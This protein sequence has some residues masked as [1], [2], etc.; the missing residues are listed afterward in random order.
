MAVRALVTLDKLDFHQCIVPSAYLRRWLTTIWFL[1]HFA[2][3][4]RL[5][6][7]NAGC[8]RF[9]NIGGSCKC[10][11]DFGGSRSQ[12]YFFTL[13]KIFKLVHSVA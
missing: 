9:D 11:L 12:E 10:F 8:L 6:E 1:T 7:N 4:A 2:A 13:C 5:V 3:V